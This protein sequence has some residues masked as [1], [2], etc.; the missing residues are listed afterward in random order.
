MKEI[1][2]SIS[3]LIGISLRTCSKA[4]ILVWTMD[5]KENETI[6]SGETVAKHRSGCQ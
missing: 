5:K 2:Y 3:L 4:R 1:I 6:A